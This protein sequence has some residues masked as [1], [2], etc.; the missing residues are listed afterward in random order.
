MDDMYCNFKE[1]R[2]G[3]NRQWDGCSQ[4]IHA[5]VSFYCCKT[6]VQESHSH[7]ILLFHVF[8]FFRDTIQHNITRPH[9]TELKC[10]DDVCAAAGTNMWY[11]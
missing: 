3:D 4:I 8:S 5:Q 1:S 11:R 9:L 7:F 10:V 6:I 2:V